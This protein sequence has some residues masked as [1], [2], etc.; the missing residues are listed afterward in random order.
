MQYATLQEIANKISE[1]ESNIENYEKQLEALGNGADS[2]SVYASASGIVH[3]DNACSLYII[4]CAHDY[5]ISRSSH[6]RCLPVLHPDLVL[7]RPVE[8]QNSPAASPT[9]AYSAPVLQATHR[10]S[11]FQ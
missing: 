1:L 11:R 10:G 2:Y 9:T 8:R 4:V 5:I 7:P 3:M 6:L